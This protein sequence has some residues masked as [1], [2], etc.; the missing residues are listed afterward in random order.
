[1]VPSLANGWS[2]A[3]GKTGAELV[4]CSWQPTYCTRGQAHQ[5]RPPLMFTKSSANAAVGGLKPP[6]AG[7]LRRANN[8]SSPA[9]HHLKKLAYHTPFSVRDTRGSRLSQAKPG[10][11]ATRSH[12]HSAA[13]ESD[14]SCRKIWSAEYGSHCGKNRL[15]PSP[16]QTRS[17]RP[18]SR[19]CCVSLVW[20]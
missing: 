10:L 1:V 5:A 9:Q 8:P 20:P 7:R 15:R 4:P 17:T 3:H 19:E 11:Q 12:G 2:H 14:P 6:P 18:R 16:H 13:R